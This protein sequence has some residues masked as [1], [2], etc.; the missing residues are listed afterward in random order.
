MNDVEP[1]QSALSLLS[2]YFI[3]DSSPEVN[4]IV[5]SE[6]LVRVLKSALYGSSSPV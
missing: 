6:L 2:S 4:V 5:T 3:T 1:A